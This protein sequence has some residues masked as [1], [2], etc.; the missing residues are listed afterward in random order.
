MPGW[1]NVPN[2]LTAVRLALTPFVVAAILAGKHHLALALFGA[3]AIT[4]GLDGAL[5]RR[6][7][8]ITRLGAYLDPIADKTLLSGTCLALALSARIPVWF[9]VLVFGRDLLILAGAAA[10]MAFAG[11]RRF[12]PTVWG[13]LST[14]LQSLY[15]LSVLVAAA[16]PASHWLAVA[17][18]WPAAI[19]TAWSGV[20]Y[21]IIAAKPASA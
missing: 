3:A 9:V 18:L 15:T 12:P 17:L 1:L 7:H 11:R 5:A 19:A 20:H 2:S 4:D 14:L 13:K 21:A 6:L 16:V 8:A 10:L